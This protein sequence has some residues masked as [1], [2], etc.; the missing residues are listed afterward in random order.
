M[1][2]CRVLLTIVS[3]PKSIIQFCTLWQCIGFRG[4]WNMRDSFVRAK[5]AAEPPQSNNNTGWC[6]A[7]AHC[8]FSKANITNL[9]MFSFAVIWLLF[10]FSLVKI[11]KPTFFRRIF[12]HSIYLWF[13]WN[14]QFLGKST[15]KFFIRKLLQAPHK[16]I[17]AGKKTVATHVAFHH[18]QCCYFPLPER[19]SLA[20]FAS[21]LFTTN[22]LSIY[23]SERNKK[24]DVDDDDDADACVENRLTS[25]KS[26][27]LCAWYEIH[28]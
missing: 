16:C 1:T 3:E 19:L 28:S 25:S 9:Q 12:Q 2:L 14:I 5:I 13:H 18:W 20:M 4:N 27:T 10:G 17:V 11:N 21:V 7:K 24:Y 22:H 26:C 23:S 6:L 8:S 15:P